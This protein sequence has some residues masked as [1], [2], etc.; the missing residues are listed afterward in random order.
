MGDTGPRA[1]G[2]GCLQA[3][4]PIRFRPGSPGRTI[5]S[6]SNVPGS[7]TAC[8]SAATRQ[9]TNPRVLLGREPTVSTTTAWL[10]LVLAGL[11]EITWAFGLKYTGHWTRLGP[12]VFVLVAYL[13]GLYLL[14][15]PMQV[16]PAGTAYSVWVGI[17]TIGVTVL[18]IVLLGESASLPRLAC[19]GL[20]LLGVVGLRLLPA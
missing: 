17:G 6:Q 8:E 13:V 3:R 14:S 5:P 19:L 10:V 15:V 7:C 1:V 2:Q 20:I 12:S 16:L 11:V 18:G 4:A 9:P